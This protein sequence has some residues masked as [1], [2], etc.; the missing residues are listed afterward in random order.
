[1]HKNYVV[2]RESMQ[3]LHGCYEKTGYVQYCGMGPRHAH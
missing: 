3:L 2:A 1:M